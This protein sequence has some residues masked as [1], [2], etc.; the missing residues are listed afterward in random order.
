VLIVLRS[1]LIFFAFILLGACHSG[2]SALFT[3]RKYT[4]GLYFDVAKHVPEA[5]RS[6]KIEK[7]IKEKNILVSADKKY[8][9]QKNRVLASVDAPTTNN[10]A[11]KDQ[12]KKKR[13]FGLDQVKTFLI[14]KIPVKEKSETKKNSTISQKRAAAFD[15]DGATVA[16]GLVGFILLTAVY[17]ISILQAS[18]GI[19]PLVAL[20]AA[21]I[22]AALSVVTGICFY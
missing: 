16:I 8:V 2:K 14:K 1:L 18:P 5:K 20:V 22:F 7:E 17:F 19:N 15:I 3:K 12:I 6:G 10:S 9:E 11:G 21:A 4:K 13:V